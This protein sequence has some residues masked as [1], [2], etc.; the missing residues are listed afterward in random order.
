[1]NILSWNDISKEKKEQ[2]LRR[3]EMDIT[4]NMKV[5]T[6]VSEDV[7]KRGDDAIVDYTAKFDR[8]VMD[9][10]RIKVTAQEI[11]DGY[12]RLDEKTREAIAYA[13]KNIRDFHEKQLPEEM[14]FTEVDKGLLVGEKNHAHRG[15]VLICTPGKGQLSFRA[16][17]AGNSGGG[18]E[19]ATNRGGDAPK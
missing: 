19:G 13:A 2:I 10:S 3:A 7:R 16:F 15:C 11:E 18:G 8:V 17:D 4:A 12:N 9:K 14:W 1:M 6:E 5:A